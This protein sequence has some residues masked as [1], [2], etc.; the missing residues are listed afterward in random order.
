[1]K[2]RPMTTKGKPNSAKGTGAPP[3]TAAPIQKMAKPPHIKLKG[4]KKTSLFVKCFAGSGRP[5]QRRCSSGR[6]YG[7]NWRRTSSIRGS[8]PMGVSGSCG[9]QSEARSLGDQRAER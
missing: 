4:T 6:R 3:S 9:A 7:A 2:Y 1:M 5:H 8:C